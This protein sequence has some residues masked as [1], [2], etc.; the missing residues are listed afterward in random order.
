MTGPSDT[1]QH[2]L[3]AETATLGACLIRPSNVPEI[4]G[5]LTADDFFRAAHGTIWRAIKRLH[6]AGQTVDLLTVCNRLRSDHHLDAV[7]GPSYVSRIGDGVPR[8]TNARAYA[9]I[10]AE[11]AGK[12][13]LA[14]AVDRGAPLS[15]LTA[16]VAGLPEVVAANVDDDV[17]PWTMLDCSPD[18]RVE[19]WNPLGLGLLAFEGAVVSVTAASKQGKSTATW[20]DLAPFTRDGGKVLAIVGA[21]ERGPLGWRDYARVI[22]ATG[23]DPRHVCAMLPPASLAGVERHLPDSGIGC[24][25]I[26]SVASLMASLERNENSVEDVRRTIDALRGLGV[27][28]V[29]IRHNVNA[30][31][32]TKLRDRDASRGAGSRDWRAAVDAEAELRRGDAGVSRMTWVGRDGCPAFTGFKLDKS[33]WP[34]S[35]EVL[36]LTETDL[37]GVGSGGG[38]VHLASDGEA[39]RT[40]IDALLD[41]TP[42]SPWLMGSLEE[43][44]GAKLGRTGSK[45]GRWWKPY[46]AAVDRLYAR[47]IIGADRDPSE[48][49]SGGRP[50]KLWKLPPPSAT[51]VRAEAD[52]A[53]E[54]SAKASARGRSPLGRML[55]DASP[56]GSEAAEGADKALAEGQSSETQG[57]V[58]AGG[59]A[60]CPRCFGTGRSASGETCNHGEGRSIRRPISVEQRTAIEQTFI[61]DLPMVLAHFDG[62]IPSSP[63]QLADVLARELLG[64]GET[65]PTLRQTAETI[66]SDMWQLAAHAAEGLC[67]LHSEVTT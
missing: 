54:A 45:T 34:Y 42:E 21:S 60:D 53:L 11:F 12:R 57:G 1:L 15:E 55:V 38:G 29:L 4:A 31:S 10:V 59:G 39:E 40:V 35:V 30:G 20:A 56:E 32:D 14:S 61:S 9:S 66:P 27:P 6:D 44:V 7:G 25:V 46:R 2:N 26:D 43:A 63:A 33:T 48:R 19:P 58:Y 62:P 13:R 8:S 28:V 5:I 51:F 3:E 22:A 17:A 67:N 36:D 52:K 49:K 37:D 65:W 16:I 23:G 41:T 18:D 64:A 47:G 24:L 50:Y